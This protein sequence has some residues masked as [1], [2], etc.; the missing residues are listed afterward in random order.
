MELSDCV[1]PG[2]E[3]RLQ[4]TVVGP[5]FTVWKGSAFTE[6]N[7][8]SDQVQLRHSQFKSGTATNDCNNGTI[9]ARG[10]NKTSHSDGDKFI[11]QL[12]IQLGVNDSLDGR[13]VECV[14]D[15]QAQRITKYTYTIH[16]TRGKYELSMKQS[17]FV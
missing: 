7:C 8:S 3:L 13:T 17:S 15:H 10:I 2:H 1:C 5:G 16:Y 9:I 12:T 6:H 11:S 14:H 4:C